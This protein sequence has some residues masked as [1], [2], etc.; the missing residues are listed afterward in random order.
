MSNVE[1]RMRYFYFFLIHVELAS[2]GLVSGL[3]GKNLL[4]ILTYVVLAQLSI[5]QLNTEVWLVRIFLNIASKQF[6]YRKLA[7]VPV[8]MPA[9]GEGSSKGWSGRKSRRARA[10]Q[11]KSVLVRLLIYLF[12]SSFLPRLSV[13][14]PIDGDGLA[15]VLVGPAG[16]V[17]EM[18]TNCGRLIF[19]LLS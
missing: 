6:I 5:K 3:K 2:I 18:N 19:T 1:L 17:T 9:W 10:Y 15:V 13:E 12:C 16:V 14:W 8:S 11:D 7:R 4:F